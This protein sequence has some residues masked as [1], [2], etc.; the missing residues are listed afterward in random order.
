MQGLILIVRRNL[1]QYT[2]QIPV[3]NFVKIRARVSSRLQTMREWSKKHVYYERDTSITG[4]DLQVSTSQLCYEGNSKSN[5]HNRENKII[6]EIIFS[7]S[8]ILGNRK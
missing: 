5:R 1:Q 4:E 8:H 6:R 7:I 3:G 2:T